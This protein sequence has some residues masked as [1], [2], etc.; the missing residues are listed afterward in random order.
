MIHRAGGVW[1]IPAG[2]KGHVFANCLGVLMNIAG[3]E[4]FQFL[5]DT[6][7]YVGV[8]R[9]CKFWIFRGGRGLDI[10]GEAPK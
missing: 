3:G 10:L 1:K 7:I 6:V 2:G 8:G 4:W 9:I 5:E